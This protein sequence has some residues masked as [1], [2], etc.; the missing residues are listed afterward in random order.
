MPHAGYTPRSSYSRFELVGL[1]DTHTGDIGDV[2]ASLPGGKGDGKKRNNE[3][4]KQK[5][6]SRT[7]EKKTMERTQ[8]EIRTPTLPKAVAS[9][10]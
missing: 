8:K 2:I 4:M 3:K 10:L 9:K 1:S 5:I 6:R 7:R